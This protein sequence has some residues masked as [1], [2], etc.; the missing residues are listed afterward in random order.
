MKNRAGAPL[1]GSHPILNKRLMCKYCFNA[2][3]WPE[4][5]GMLLTQIRSPNMIF[6]DK[7]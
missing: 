7:S 6:V 5:V 1:D 3:N 2:T 4:G